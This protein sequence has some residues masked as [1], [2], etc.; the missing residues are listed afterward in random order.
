[1]QIFTF[2]NDDIT[3]T[4]HPVVVQ[5]ALQV[6]VLW[7]ESL[8]SELQLLPVERLLHAQLLKQTQ[9]YKRQTFPAGWCWYSDHT[10]NLVLWVLLAAS[11]SPDHAVTPAVVFVPTWSSRD[12]GPHKGRGPAR[13][14]THTHH[15]YSTARTEHR[16]HW[17]EQSTTI[18][19]LVQLWHHQVILSSTLTF[20]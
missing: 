12:T 20:V 2:N 6:V 13:E 8:Q 7:A 19:H 3:L 15:L 17:R 1:M 11:P 14:A 9:N 4:V 5:F 16:Q 10:Y 18:N